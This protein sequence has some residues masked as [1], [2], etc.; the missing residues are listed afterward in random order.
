MTLR[1]NL[2]VLGKI[3]KITQFFYSNRNK[4]IK[5]DKDGNESVVTISYKTKFIDSARFMATLLPN[6]IVA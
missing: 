4:V 3:Q 1:E 6:S 2:S 5:I